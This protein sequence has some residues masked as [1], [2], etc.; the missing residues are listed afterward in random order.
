[1]FCSRTHLRHFV[2]L[3]ALLGL[4]LRSLIPAGYMP[5]FSGQQKGLFSVVL[6]DGHD[7][8]AHA[9]H[10]HH[11]H[12]GKPCPDGLCAFAINAIMAFGQ[13]EIAIN[14]HPVY[15]APPRII[16]SPHF[17]RQSAF[18]NASSRSPPYF[19]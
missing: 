19:S 12:D 5:D 15:Y 14:V 2:I 13:A 18:S 3:I 7:H 10:M 4:G 9:G 16:V 6:C 11:S 8:S 17:I 1:M